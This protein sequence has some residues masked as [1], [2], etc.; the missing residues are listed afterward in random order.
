MNGIKTSD[1]QR[2]GTLSS[3]EAWKELTIAES[4]KMPGVTIDPLVKLLSLDDSLEWEAHSAILERLG[5]HNA[6]SAVLRSH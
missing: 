6:A 3:P 1:E 2:D 4:M 5:L